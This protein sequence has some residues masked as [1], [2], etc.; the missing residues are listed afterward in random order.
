M[1]YYQAIKNK[2]IMNVAGKWMEL[3]KYPG[4]DTTDPKG[5]HGM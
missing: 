1:G 4:W 5:M 3:N 2:G